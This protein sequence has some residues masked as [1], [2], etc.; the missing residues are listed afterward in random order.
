SIN[1]ASAATAK[2]SGMRIPAKVSAANAVTNLDAKIGKFLALQPEE[3]AHAI[4]NVNNRFQ[5]STPWATFA[6]GVVPDAPMPSPE[7]QERFLTRM[8]ELG[9]DIVLEISPPK[10]NEIPPPT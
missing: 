4:F 10:T 7:T 8:D 6:V 1:I 2:W 5:G 3:A 9:V